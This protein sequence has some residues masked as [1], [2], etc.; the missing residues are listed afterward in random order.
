MCPQVHLADTG[1]HACGAIWETLEP[2]G[3]GAWL[4]KVSKEETYLNLESHSYPGFF[5]ALCFLDSPDMRALYS[6]GPEPHRAL[7]TMRK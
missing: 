4:V 7:R 1:G 3:G 6:H 5:L 2:L